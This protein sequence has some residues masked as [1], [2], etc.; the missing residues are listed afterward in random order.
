MNIF[1][2]LSL[3]GGLCLFLFGMSLMGSALE[4]RAGSGLKTILGKL[5]TGK[6]VGLLT[7]L[8]VTAVIQSSSATTVMVVGFVN[9]GLMSLK[10]A[11][12][13]I[14]GAN[15]GTTVTAWI[16][17]LSGIESSNVFVR[18]LKPSSFTPILALIGIVFYMMGKTGKKKDTGV[19]LLGFATL[20]FGMET[21]SSAVAGLKEVPEFRNL[22]VMFSN[23][24]LGVAAGAV[25]T[26]V[27]Q[28]SSASVGILQALSSTGQVTFG[29][30]IPI[31]MGQNIG[32]CVTALISSVGAN[33]NAKRAA[34]VHLCFNI[35]GTVFWL[36]VFCVLNAVVQFT[37]VH[38]TINQLGIAIVHTIFNVLCTLLMLPATGLLEKLACRLIPDAKTPETETEL[39]ERLMS[40]PSIAIER[41]RVVAG[42]M[43]EAA[44]KAM[45]NSLDLLADYHQDIADS[46]RELEE[47]TDHYE[48]ILGTYLVKLSA[49]AMSE[50]DSTQSAKLL[51]MISDFERIADH[52]VN[53]TDSAQEIQQKQ[54]TFSESARRE[55]K[56]YADA[57]E[58]IVELALKA[59]TTDSTDLARKVEPL[60]E[61]VDVLKA[62][63]RARHVLRLQTGEC[64]METG[65]VWME[66]L[67]NMERAADHCSNIAGC[68]IE[69]EHGS[70]DLHDYLGELKARDPQFMDLYRGYSNKYALVEN[71]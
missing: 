11:I 48:D 68:M 64:S 4:K 22:L 21:M 3:I 40:T 59:F 14:M 9:S 45:K 39:D 51:R 13:V 42:E 2:V 69:M 26:A 47:K 16:L 5:T 31:I 34:M 7:G 71:G 19:I 27:I 43:A 63:L 29:A 12:N 58:E 10:Q 61:V 53:L 38:S 33:K 49:H 67:T 55:L 41:C 56:I 32:T 65:F 30:A 23:P 60:E 18:L 44:V 20:M 35:I 36:T 66:L 17:S 57:V 50:G 6:L 46:V 37:F 62:Q 25:L 24:I 8:G 52:A 70:L 28:S 15:V 54:L 1:D